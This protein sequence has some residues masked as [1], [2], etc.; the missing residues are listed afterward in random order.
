MS[1][2]IRGR[3]L[4]GGGSFGTVDWW[5]GVERVGL[6]HLREEIGLFEFVCRVVRI[7]VALVC[8]FKGQLGLF[9]EEEVDSV[10]LEDAWDA[11]EDIVVCY[12]VF[13]RVRWCMSL[14]GE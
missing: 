5:S 12:N 9:D 1:I 7:F 11:E 13:S 8:H 4:G 14:S 6:G 2:V 10:P 3:L